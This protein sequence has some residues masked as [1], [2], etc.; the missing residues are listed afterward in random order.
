MGVTF[1]DL[2]A[3]DFDDMESFVSGYDTTMGG[4]I[5][6]P[7]SLAWVA[8]S[9]P[10]LQKLRTDGAEL[11][12]RLGLPDHHEAVK[13]RGMYVWIEIERPDLPEQLHVPRIW[14]AIG[15]APFRPNL[16]CSAPHGVTFPLTEPLEQG[17]PEA[18]H[19]SCKAARIELTCERYSP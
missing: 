19:K 2:E 18:V 8:E 14:D 4:Q 11:T 17:F 9:C 5:G 6:K 1:S 7:R 16:D 13:T 15:H 12:R 10:D 3:Y